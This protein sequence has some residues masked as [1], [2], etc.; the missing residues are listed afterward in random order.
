MSA[1]ASKAV[2]KIL[3]DRV[4][5]QAP[6]DPHIEII[7]DAKGKT[8]KVVRP[9]PEGLSKR[10]KK[11]LKKIRRRAHYLDKG[12]NLCGFRVGW[13]F[14]IGII[15]GLGDVVD[16]GLNYCLVVRPSRKLDIPDSLLSKMLV[17]NAISAGLGFI[18]IAGDIFLAAWKANS[19]NAHLL[20]E[21]LKIRGQELLAAQ[22]QGPSGIHPDEAA[23][24]GL[25]PDVLRQLFAPGSGMSAHEDAE[26]GQG[27]KANTKPVRA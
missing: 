3:K 24:V 1:L 14:F 22:G 26:T 9:L 11:A 10:D 6:P 5:T 7:V 2:T 19:R 4:S 21:F 12:M 17:N 15:P 16:A 25:S 8:K 13:T 20:E 23:A 27:R 18:P